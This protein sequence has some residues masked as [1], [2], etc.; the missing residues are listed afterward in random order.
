MKRVIAVSVV[1]VFAVS[2]LF[3]TG[4]AEAEVVK[5][6]DILF[7]AWPSA[8]VEFDMIQEFV[9]WYNENNDMQV[10]VTYQAPE[11]DYA[12]ALVTAFAAGNAPDVYFGAN[13]SVFDLGLAENLTPLINSD[14]EVDPN[15]LLEL[16][17]NFFRLRQ[18]PNEDVYGLSVG[19][20]TNLLF[21]N[22]TLFQE[23]GVEDPAV[24]YAN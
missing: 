6:V 11:G 10:T 5:P 22:K 21:Y 20:T 1:L 14:P 13:Q 15:D 18:D 17:L 16:S 9:A 23:M 2:A 24:Q 12:Q 8:G 7:W 4:P 3:A 19:W